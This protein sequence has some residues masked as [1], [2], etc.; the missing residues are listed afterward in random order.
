LANGSALATL[1]FVIAGCG[2]PAPTT[3][4]HQQGETSSNLLEVSFR[5]QPFDTPGFIISVSE[6]PKQSRNYNFEVSSEQANVAKLYSGS[7]RV[8]PHRP[9]PVTFTVSDSQRSINGTLLTF[10]EVHDRLGVPR[11]A[12]GHVN[13]D[14]WEDGASF[15]PDGRYLLMQYSPITITGYLNQNPEAPEATTVRGPI[16][17]PERPGFPKN[18]ISESGEVT[19]AFPLYGQDEL[20]FSFPPTALF[21]FERGEGRVWNAL[22]A[23]GPDDGGNGSLGTFGPGFVTGVADRSIVFA[24]NDPRTNDEADTNADIYLYQWEPVSPGPLGRFFRENQSIEAEGF[25]PVL[26]GPDPAGHQGNPHLHV[27]ANEMSLW[28][29]DETKSEKDIYLA[30]SPNPRPQDATWTGWMP[31]PAPINEADVEETQPFFDGSILVLRKGNRIVAFE[32]LGG[33]L[34]SADSWSRMQVWLTP[35]TRREPGV[36]NVV[37]E[38]SLFTMRGRKHLGFVYGV[39]EADGTVNLDVGYVPITRR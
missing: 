17:A 22:G 26:I 21:V 18:L 30:T 39:A 2:A 29:D 34:T 15:S 36:I 31:L 38:P 10:K 6:P 4:D 27:G 13:T 7:W 5:A 23:F 33:S 24:F 37:G 20:P 9:G 8:E 12:E 35:S 1:S 11:A 32:Y 19:N 25:E 16:Q 28:V 3:T 14:A